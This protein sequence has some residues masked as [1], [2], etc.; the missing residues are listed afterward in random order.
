MLDTSSVGFPVVA[1][2]AT[3]P[4]MSRTRS[5]VTSSNSGLVGVSMLHSLAGIP[6]VLPVGPSHTPNDIP[7]SVKVQMYR[8][9]AAEAGGDTAGQ[10]RDR[11]YGGR[12]GPAPRPGDRIGAR[13][14]RSVLLVVE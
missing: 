11:A 4:A 1:R 12:T 3:E 10:R 7:H 2:T 13:P 8:E 5:P 6:L 14:G 9:W